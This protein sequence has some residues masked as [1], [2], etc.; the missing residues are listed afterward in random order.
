M[1]RPARLYRYFVPEASDL[2]AAQ[3]LWVSAASDFNDVFEVVPRYDKLIEDQYLAEVQKNHAFLPPEI[4]VSWPEYKRSMWRLIEQAIAED[5]EVLP[6]GF[7]KKFSEHFGIVCFGTKLD[8]LLMWGHYTKSHSGFV[9][10]FDPRHSMFDPTEFGKVEYSEVRP[11]VDVI[12]YRKILLQ[13][14]PEWS[15][16]QEYR[17]IKPVALLPKAMR[18]DN[19][20]KHFVSL[21]LDAV[22]AVYFGLRMPRER[23]DELL[24]SLTLPGR[25]HI[26]KYA[27][28]RHR[29]KYAIT[30]V[31]WAEVKTAPTDAKADFDGLW[32]AIGL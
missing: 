11:L 21:P 17:L 7:Q 3:Q 27:M 9:V 8:C 12:D 15:Y 19:R 10:E 20:E 16:E 25:E 26:A 4:N 13:K 29:E 31:A 24:S 5:H 32:K 30:P 2:L 1:S 28:R 22:R 14:S 6:E 23:R 18:R